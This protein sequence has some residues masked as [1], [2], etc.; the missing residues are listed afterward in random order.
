MVKRVDELIMFDDIPN[1]GDGGDG[2][3]NTVDELMMGSDAPSEGEEPGAGWVSSFTFR[4][5]R[6]RLFFLLVVRTESR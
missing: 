4:R 1:C 5:G 2:R 3:V 6:T